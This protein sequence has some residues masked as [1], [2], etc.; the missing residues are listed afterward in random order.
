MDKYIV[1]GPDGLA[2]KPEPC[3]SLE[4]AFDELAAFCKRYVGQGC[5]SQADGTRLPVIDL[6]SECY[7]IPLTED[8]VSRWHFR[9]SQPPGGSC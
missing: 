6:P 8:A 4:A 9:S 3:D 7:I 2:T 5:Y 1:I